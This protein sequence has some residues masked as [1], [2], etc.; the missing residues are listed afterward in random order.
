MALMMC[1]AHTWADN[2][3]PS[4]NANREWVKTAVQDKLNQGKIDEAIALL[5]EHLKEDKK[6]AE[7]WGR[8]AL[9]QSRTAKC[10]DAQASLTQASAA[11]PPNTRDAYL[12]AAEHLRTKGCT[13]LVESEK[14]A[15]VGELKS[16][17]LLRIGHDN[18]V[19]LLSDS[20]N[21]SSSPESAFFNPVAQVRYHRPFSSGNLELRST[22]S[23]TGYIKSQVDSYNSIYQFLAAEWEPS[24][25]SASVWQTRFGNRFDV[26]FVNSDGM[27]FFSWTDTVFANLSRD[28]NEYSRLGFEIPV[29]LQKF[30]E[31]TAATSDDNRDGAVVTPSLWYAKRVDS[32]IWQ[33]SLNFS[34]VF[35]EGDNYRLQAYG[36]SSGISGRM[37]ELIRGRLN[38]SFAQNNYF[39]SSNGRKDDRFDAIVGATYTPASEPNLN[40][41]FDIFVTNNNSNISSASYKRNTVMGQVEYA[42]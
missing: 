6:D 18:N 19:M 10:D 40:F 16:S 12:I 42:F 33:S 14:A 28:L 22:T 24:T 3:K 2:S 36:I 15:D 27:R 13:A 8:L 34:Q 41:A 39:E 29:G 38:F 21:S 17:V 25:N 23:Y 31:E 30:A 9:L 32:L 37:T 4:V 1:S 11:S 20:L 26:S 7:S 5:Q 35:A